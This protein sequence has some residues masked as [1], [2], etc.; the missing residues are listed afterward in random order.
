MN[1]VE[2][3]REIY[4]TSNDPKRVKRAFECIAKIIQKRISNKFST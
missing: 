2:I 3:L 4:F 1:R